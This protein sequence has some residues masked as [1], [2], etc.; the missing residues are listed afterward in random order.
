MT[1]M[2][3]EYRPPH[4]RGYRGVAA[5]T[6]VSLFGILLWEA[7][8]RDMAW[9]GAFGD[10]NGFAWR[11]HWLFSG[12]LHEGGR[13]ASWALALG[14]CL[15]VWWPMGILRRIDL[16]RRLQLVVTVMMA[17]ALVSAMKVG[18]GSS[19]PWDMQAFGGVAHHVPHWRLW[20]LPDGGSGHCFPAGH[21]SAGFSFLAGWFAFRESPRVANAWLCGAIGAG[22]LFGLAQQ[23]RGAH[24]MSHTLWTG[25]ICWVVA[26]GMDAAWPRFAE[27]VA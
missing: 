25:W 27:V 1:E 22:L 6:L 8:G 23:V 3:K 26:W 10:G 4:G 7:A 2:R 16:S 15:G 11:S 24:F 12:V 5:A 14:L 9:A 17:S 19:C 20:G 21:A 18:S 13:R